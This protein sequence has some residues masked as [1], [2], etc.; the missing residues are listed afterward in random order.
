[1]HY[2]VENDSKLE[3]DAELNS[4]LNKASVVWVRHEGWVLCQICTD[5]GRARLGDLDPLRCNGPEVFAKC[6]SVE[7]G[8]R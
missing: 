3:P 4:Y 6:Y 2:L 8:L 1:M 7:R 5:W